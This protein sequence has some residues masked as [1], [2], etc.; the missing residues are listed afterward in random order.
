[1]KLV[2]YSDKSIEELDKLVKIFEE[3]PNYNIEDHVYEKSSFT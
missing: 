2:L 3:I 1:M